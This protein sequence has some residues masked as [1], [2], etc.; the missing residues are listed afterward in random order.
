[1]TSEHSPIKRFFL[2]TWWFI[3]GARKVFLNLVF[4]LVLFLVFGL[5]WSVDD[6]L[7]VQPSSALVF[8]PA[9][10]G[11]VEFTGTPPPHPGGRS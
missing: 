7:I 10:R 8:K 11:G 9:G 1:M 4:F 2:G 6:L 3:N 5:F